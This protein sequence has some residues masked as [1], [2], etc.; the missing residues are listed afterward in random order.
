ML[1]VLDDKEILV[2]EMLIKDGI[3]D[4]NYFFVC[5]PECMSNY[6]YIKIILVTIITK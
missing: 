4:K 5:R 6:C 3:S 1:V 2:F